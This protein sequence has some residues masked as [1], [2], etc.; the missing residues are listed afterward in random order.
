MDTVRT[1]AL[2][3]ALLATLTAAAQ[4]AGRK[5]WDEGWA[6]SQDGASQDVTYAKVLSVTSR[7]LRK[8]IRL[9]VDGLYPDAVVYVNG[10]EAGGR[11]GASVSWAVEIT[12]FLVPG[13]NVIKMDLGGRPLE[14]GSVWLTS[15]EKTAVALW[16]SALSVQPADEGT[17]RVTQRLTIRTDGLQVADI[18]TLILFRGAQRLQTV[19]EARSTERVYD[20]KEVV[21]SFDLLDARLWSPGAPNLYIARTTVEGA[22]GSKDVYETT[23]G[24]RSAEFR[25]DGFYLNGEKTV[26]KAVRLEDSTSRDR[27]VWAR[28]LLVMKKLGCNTLEVGPNPPLPQLLDLCDVLGLM[29]ADTCPAA[30]E[31]G[32]VTLVRRDRNH[33]SV[34]LWNVPEALADICRREDP[35]RPVADS[36]HRLDAVRPERETHPAGAGVRVVPSL[37]YKGEE[38]CFV[39]AQILDRAGV[40]VTDAASRIS[41]SVQGP[42]VLAG[43]DAGDPALPFGMASALVRRTGEGPVTVTVMAKG[44][45]KAVITL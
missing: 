18:H 45:R 44:L 31:E 39:T 19:A 21:Q 34:I 12:P 36:V 25:A 8:D 1:F 11:F 32:V 5:S 6:S 28:R 43:G 37:D 2:A 38:L 35:A 22:D 3:A 41:F 29:V 15:T 30:E 9:E 33:P 16:G 7:D 40:G 13:S 17:A 42:A 27:D 4:P 26:P 20:G 10:Q 14:D 24:I 23:F